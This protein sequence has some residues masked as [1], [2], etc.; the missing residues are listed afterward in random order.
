MSNSVITTTMQITRT[1]GLDEY[2]TDNPETSLFTYAY[3]RITPFAK[4]TLMIPFN[5]KVSFG[6]TITATV[7]F[8]GDL[9][10]TLHLYFR[11]PQLSPPPPG[12]TYLGWVN[13]IGYAMIE[14]VQIRIGGNYH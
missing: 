14:S 1:G 2:L 11:L 9:V 12:S 6:K 8:L 10:H 7:P 5:E 13:S 4:N 3:R